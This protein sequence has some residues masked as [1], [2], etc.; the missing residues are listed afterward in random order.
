M[1]DIEIFVRLSLAGLSLLITII[2]L[3]SFVKVRDGKIA[4]ASTGF[5]FFAVL[6]VLLCFGIFF[7]AVEAFVSVELTAGIALLA[8]IFFYLSILKR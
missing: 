3:V 7:P 4:L 6:G 8:L 5:F 1:N 2:S